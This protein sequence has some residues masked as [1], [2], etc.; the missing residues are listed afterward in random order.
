MTADELIDGYVAEVVGLLPRA[1]RRDVALELRQL[2]SEEVAAAP[3]RAEAARALLAG[4]G[5][6]AEVA[7][8]YGTPVTLIDPADTRRFLTLAAGGAGLILFAAV[9]HELIERAAPQRDLERAGQQALPFVFA[10]L[11]LLLAGFAVAAWARRRRPDTGWQPRPVPTDRINRLGRAAGLAFY[12]LGTL[13]LLDPARVIVPLAGEAAE[14]ALREAFAYDGD[15]LRV[16][17]PVLLA[18]LVASLVVEAVLVVKGRWFPLLHHVTLGLGLVMCAVLTWV[19]G[20]GPVFTA[21][22]TDQTAKEIVGLIVLGS[23]I[24]LAVRARKHHVRR[25]VHH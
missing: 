14:P 18:L 23:L 11:G 3:D 10:W 19:I 16:R 25:A 15:F 1:Q 22:L 20:A 13:V 9:L 2:L 5:R 21:A 17:G 24:D 4:F 12:I 7:A 8:R 6:P